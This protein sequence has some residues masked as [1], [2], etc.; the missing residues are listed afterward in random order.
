M[1][2]PSAVSSSAHRYMATSN[3]AFAVVGATHRHARVG[4]PNPA[5]FLGPGVLASRL[6]KLGSCFSIDSR[7]SLC[8]ATQRISKLWPLYKNGVL[9]QFCGGCNHKPVAVEIPMVISGVY[10]QR[11]TVKGRAQWGGQ[12]VPMA[13]VQNCAL[14]LRQQRREAAGPGLA[15]AVARRR[16]ALHAGLPHIN[17]RSKGTLG[18]K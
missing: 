13:W 9:G 14:V 6:K 11:G 12:Q 8:V 1:S 4:A 5:E 3:A 10:L 7:H 16:A 15:M 2:A 18:G 17:S